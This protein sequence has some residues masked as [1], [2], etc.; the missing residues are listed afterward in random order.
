MTVKG[1]FHQD[2][3]TGKWAIEKALVYH[4]ID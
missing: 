3:H 4:S 1:L 2:R